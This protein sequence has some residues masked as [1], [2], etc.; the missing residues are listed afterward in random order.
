[1]DFLDDLL[2]DVMQEE[3]N[4]MAEDGSIGEVSRTLMG[5]FRQCVQGNY[6]GVEELRAKTALIQQRNPSHQSVRAPAT[7]P[8]DDEDSSDDDDEDDD[9]DMDMDDAAVPV[10]AAVSTT[11]TVTTATVE[12]LDE[13]PA[14]IDAE[15]EGWE[16]VS[17]HKKGKG[18]GGRN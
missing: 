15:D 9:G 7:N 5:L 17:T 3:F 18:R 8:S 12:M 10:S 16:T 4:T 6:A 1:V 2:D 14:L 11:T 13:A